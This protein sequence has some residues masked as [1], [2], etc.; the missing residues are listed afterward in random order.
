MRPACVQRLNDANSCTFNAL[1][2]S[3]RLG[4]DC[5]G[6][7]CCG[8]I[9][10]HLVSFAAW[11]SEDLQRLAVTLI[12]NIASTLPEACRPA[13]LPLH[14]RACLAHLD[15]RSHFPE[16]GDAHCRGLLLAVSAASNAQP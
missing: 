8:K 1:K 6:A 7:D 16:I 15:Q 2:P 3:L 11:D 4:A 14:S 12:G 13:E 5:I 10:S 9:W